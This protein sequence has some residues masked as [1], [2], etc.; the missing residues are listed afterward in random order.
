MN[1]KKIL[2]AERLL[3][4]LVAETVRP[5]LCFAGGR[6]SVSLLL[7]ARHLGLQ[8][9]LTVRIV[10]IPSEDG[11]GII[12]GLS[13]LV[14]EC[15]FEAEIIPAPHP[16]APHS[17][18]VLGAF[19]IKNDGRLRGRVKS[20]V[21]V[22]A[23]DRVGDDLGAMEFTTNWAKA[24]HDADGIIIGWRCLDR[25]HRGDVAQIIGKFQRLKDGRYFTLPLFHWLDR[26]LN[27]YLGLG[28]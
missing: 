15:G 21:E 5:V 2:E 1:R 16:E 17:D 13:V 14:R 23:T 4:R 20:G 22:R 27:E 28:P 8:D 10:D 3:C 9:V 6:E 18:F 26:D 7:L 24:T 25:G 19:P 12:P 11:D